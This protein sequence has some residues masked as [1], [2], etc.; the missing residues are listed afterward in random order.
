M[1]SGIHR[2]AVMLAILTL[3]VA[4]LGCALFEDKMLAI[5]HAATLDEARTVRLVEYDQRNAVLR[6]PEHNFTELWLIT[7][8][9][10]KK[11]DKPVCKHGVCLPGGTTMHV[12]ARRGAEVGKSVERF[13]F[14]QLEAYRN[15]TGD[16]VWIVDRENGRVV[17][18]LDLKT[19]AATGPDDE[20]PPW[21]TLTWGVR[22]NPVDLD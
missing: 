6:G 9:D 2:V 1:R 20:P 21:A 22:L 18:T 3:G 19:S 11:S 5:R 17:A 16:Q 14:G 15:T 7:S 10:T 8:D 13:K 12:I 4:N